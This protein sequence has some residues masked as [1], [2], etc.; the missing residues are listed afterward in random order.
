MDN[1]SHFCFQYEWRDEANDRLKVEA[2]PEEKE[3]IFLTDEHT[4]SDLIGCPFSFTT[5]GDFADFISSMIQ[6]GKDVFGLDMFEVK[7]VKK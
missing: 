7:E 5:P 4:E 2:Y 3:V 6:I 1:K